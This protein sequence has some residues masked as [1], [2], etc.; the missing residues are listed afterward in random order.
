MYIFLKNIDE[1]SDED[2]IV[3]DNE[4]DIETTTSLDAIT[5]ENLDLSKIVFNNFRQVSFQTD[6]EN[7]IGVKYKNKIF[8]ATK[9]ELTATTG[10]VKT[11]KTFIGQSGTVET[12]TMEV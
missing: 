3:A 12:G 10:D 11:G 8:Y 7:I 6:I 2:T 5:S 1:L 4:L 9:N